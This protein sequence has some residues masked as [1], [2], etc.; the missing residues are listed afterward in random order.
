MYGARHGLGPACKFG[1]LGLEDERGLLRR[2]GYRDRETA[3]AVVA[4]DHAALRCLRTLSLG[5]D[6]HRG[7]GGIS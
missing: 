6:D 4:G 7:T 3:V 1:D 5:D 2:C